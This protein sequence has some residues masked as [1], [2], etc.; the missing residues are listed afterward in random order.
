MI[1]LSF[2]YRQVLCARLHILYDAYLVT[3]RLLSSKGYEAE[4]ET[5]KGPYHLLPQ[6]L[7]IRLNVSSFL[8]NVIPLL[9]KLHHHI[10]ATV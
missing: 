8:K 7:G 3:P 10:C 5:L 2:I 1:E 9:I 6:D 4:P